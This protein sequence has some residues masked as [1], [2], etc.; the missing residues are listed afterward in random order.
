MIYDLAYRT[1]VCATLVTRSTAIDHSLFFPH[2]FSILY[3]LLLIMQLYDNVLYYALWLFYDLERER[4][5]S[6]RNVYNIHNRY[7][8]IA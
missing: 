8:P 4:G 3:L 2:E 7:F 6:G 5:G 1:L